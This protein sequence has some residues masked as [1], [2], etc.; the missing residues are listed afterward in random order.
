MKVAAAALNQTPLDWENNQANILTAIEQAQ[1]AG[2]RLLCLPEMCITGYGCEDM[3][4]SHWVAEKA[5]QIVLDLLPATQNLAVTLGL[6]WWYEG[7][8]YNTT[9]VLD[10]GQILGIQAKQHLPGYGVHY[11]PRWFSPWPAGKLGSVTVEGQS[12]PFGDQIFTIDNTRIGFEICEDA[13]VADRPACRLTGRVDMILNPSASHFS[14]MKSRV[15]EEKAI[16]AS[17]DFNCTYVFVNMLGNEA[18]RIIYDGDVWIARHG[19]LLASNTLFSFN[20]VEMSIADTGNPAA[21]AVRH[22]HGS[23]NEQFAAALTLALFDYWRKSRSKGFV[24]SLSGGADSAT[25]LVLLAE[26]IKRARQALGAGEFARRLGMDMAAADQPLPELTRQ[27]ITTAYQATRHS[28]ERTL[29]AAQQLAASVGARFFHWSV[30]TTTQQAIATIEEAIGRPLSWQEDD[31]ALQNIQARNRSPL[32]WLLANLQQ[33]LLITTSNRSEGSVGYATMDG[34]TSGSLAPIAGIDKPFIRQWLLWAQKELGYSGLQ[35]VNSL[36]PTA[37]LRPAEHEQT[38]E[39]DLMPYDVLNQIERAFIWQ[40]MSPQ[41]IHHE[42]AKNLPEDRAA[43]YV[44]KFFTLWSRNQWKRERLAP[45]FM[46]DDYNID[47]RSWYR[48]PILSGG[49]ES[50]LAALRKLLT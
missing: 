24:L 48:F 2:A 7:K 27:L 38:D 3:F 22:R 46:I 8:L 11:E 26:T 34:D 16:A 17:R 32:I 4:N 42:L 23:R 29:E 39:D 5:Q 33:A 41:Q 6:P 20:R 47:P 21:S 10:R 37:E 44:I 14:L 15:R 13:W 1:A 25:C 50:E 12:Y 36:T 30:D 35:V 18:G 31:I 28:S 43:R 40:R 9:V 45:S 19:N 49:F